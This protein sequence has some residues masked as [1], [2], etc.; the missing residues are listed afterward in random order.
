[1]GSDS[2]APPSVFG[3]LPSVR[4]GSGRDTGSF[5]PGDFEKQYEELF[6]EALE[7][8]E[9]SPEERQRLNLAAAALGLD[10]ERARRLESTR[11]S[12]PTRRTRR[13][14][15]S[16]APIR[17]R[18]P[19]T[20]RLRRSL[21]S[22]F[23][24]VDDDRPTPVTNLAPIPDENAALHERFAACRSAAG[25]LDVQFCTAAVLVRRKL[26]TRDEARVFEAHRAAD[27]RR[28]RR[29]ASR[30]RRGRGS[31]IPTR[32]GAPGTCSP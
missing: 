4:R 19:I 28:A 21:A 15:W 11:S 2:S 23:F 13:S 9:I 12:T 14:R 8:G 1:M 6:A 16:I 3:D 26:A 7:E 32:T 27:R 18:S 31:F 5:L 10:G 24:Y 29:A 25:E 22:G 30:P 20:R 17:A